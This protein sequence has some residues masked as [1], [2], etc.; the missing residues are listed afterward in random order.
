[1]SSKAGPGKTRK[2]KRHARGA[3]LARFPER[4]AE[5]FD[6]IRQFVFT[7]AVRR[8]AGAVLVALLLVACAKESG[9]RVKTKRAQHRERDSSSGVLGLSSES[10]RTVAV[11][12]PGAVVGTI[13]LEGTAPPPSDAAAIASDSSGCRMPAAKQAASKSTGLANAVVW[14][15][16][17]DSGKAL[18][19]EK[20]FDLA[21]EDCQLDPRVQG[22]V[23]GSTFDVLNVDRV[24]HRLI[25]TR[26]GT[27]DTL[28]VMPFF[29]T[30][31]VVA[32]ERIAKGPGLVEVR[33]VQH[34]WTHAYIAVFNH[35]YFAV[36]RADGSFRIDSMP[37][38]NYR[39]MVWHEGVAQPIERSVTVAAGGEAKVDVGIALTR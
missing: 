23:V 39:V 3:S 35:P 1:V 6:V 5:L 28:T 37:A 33:C 14:I 13:K 36:T 25:F 9:D 2:P 18:P 16:D 12:N 30:G 27:R 15:A 29:N 7:N 34:P 17:A 4:D 10:Y 26:F 38:G 31:Q 21:S 24:L 32:S 19:R 20:R 22:A 8:G 11:T